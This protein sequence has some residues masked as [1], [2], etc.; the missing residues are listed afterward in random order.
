ME[1]QNEELNSMATKN[2]SESE[3]VQSKSELPVE[4][5]TE[6][7]ATEI[8][9]SKESVK[10]V[11]PKSVEEVPVAAEEKPEEVAST[12]SL[13]VATEEVTVSEE[14]EPEKLVDN[15]IAVD[16]A[17]EK[18]EEVKEEAVVTDEKKSEELV[19]NIIAVAPVAEK[20]EEVK[21]EAAVSDEKESEELVDNNI[22]DAPVTKKP[23]E[24]KNEV[25][26]S[27]EKES[28]ELTEESEEEVLD[29]SSQTKAQLIEILI[30]L[31]EEG[32]IKRIDQHLKLVKPCFDGIFGEEKAEALK[33]FLS[34]EGANEDDFNYQYSEEDQQF[35]HIYSQ[36]RDKRH[37]YYKQLENQK[38]TNLKR[39]E[40]IL[41]EIRELVDGEETNISLKAIRALQDEWKTV[42]P[43]PNNF[44]RTLWA[45]YHALLDRFYDARSIYFELKE[46]DRKKNLTLKVELCEKAEALTTLENVRDAIVQL[47][48]LHEEYKHLGPVPME[49]QEALWQRFKAASDQV[50]ERR[51]GFYDQMK[52][53]LT[54]NL[55][56][57]RKLVEDMAS[58]VSFSSDRITEW[59]SKTQELLATQK[60]WDALGG[61]PKEHSK[62][63]N[64]QFWGNFKQFFAAKNKFFKSLES[65]KEGNL[66]KKV[67]L[68]E[69][70]ES[71]Q[72]SSDWVKTT[73][74]LK[75]M[76][77][78]WRD[79]GPIPDAN[80]KELFKR[81]KTACDAFFNQRRVINQEQDLVFEENL[82]KKLTICESL[83]NQIADGADDLDGIYA[84]ID[85][86]LSI[87]F[88]P[89]KA[90]KKISKKF[91]S[92]VLSLE[93]SS[94][95]TDDDKEDLKM[96]IQ[97]AKFKGSPNG[98]SMKH[99][100]EQA[101]K[102][103]ISTLEGDI[104]TY[105]TN[106]E[107]FAKSKTADKL[108]LEMEGH[109]S[110]GQKSLDDLKRELKAIRNL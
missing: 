32:S 30:G 60:K 52:E 93:K 74:L 39:K 6:E 63:I 88:V 107:F 67:E 75:R 86:Y 14:K 103:K 57:K 5:A 51:K 100:K 29:F 2:E 95:L 37:Q 73:E 85:E 65:Q 91:D 82:K 61:V 48:E 31:E 58:C 102:R 77:V 35:H 3:A 44:N 9:D 79:I 23:E 12:E 16:P 11:E 19:D 42:G 45:N 15:S 54:A 55:H 90:I 108:K 4:S 64:K 26:V 28:E 43:V 94:K 72:A 81:F 25:A 83:E 53:E 56:L 27:D 106:I 109:I 33:A 97:V 68:V 22:A 46:L 41:N 70:A 49:E 59:N 21:E 38:D 98:S 13:E 92:I 10:E 47:N 110:A 101:I 80:K 84:Y 24:V 89:K 36:L 40:E 34:E 66:T 105:K 17:V 71:L 62:E 87:G 18:P 7:I 76:Q 1:K 20:L 50:Y 78:E 99:R 69:K 8:T 104:S 96:H